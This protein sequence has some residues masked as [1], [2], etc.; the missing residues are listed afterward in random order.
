MHRNSNVGSYSIKVMSHVFNVQRIF[1]ENWWN[2]VAKEKA[3]HVV[4]TVPT[5]VSSKRESLN[6]LHFD[7]KK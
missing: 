2:T 7:F 1:F 5:A 3:Q 4:P 6:I